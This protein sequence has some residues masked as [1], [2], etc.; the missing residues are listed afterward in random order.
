MKIAIALQNSSLAGKKFEI[1]ES[2]SLTVGRSVGSNIQ[3]NPNDEKIVSGNHA[4]IRFET[5]GFYLIDHNSTNGTFVNGQRI[6]RAKLNQG[7]VIHF[8]KNGPQATVFIDD[9]HQSFAPQTILPQIQQPA[10]HQQ[11]SQKIPNFQPQPSFNANIQEQPNLNNSISFVGLGSGVVKTEKES[12]TG[13]YVGIAVAIFAIIFLSLIVALIMF[14]S[15]GPVAAVI[16]S[17]VAF[18]PA[19]FYILPLI[20]LD[21]YD[22]EPPWLLSM[23]FAWGALVA[24]IASFIV[25]TIIG[26]IAGREIG[27]IVSAPIIEEATKGIGVLLVLIFFRREFDDIL[28]GIVYAGVVALG[29]ATVENILYYGRVINEGGMQCGLFEFARGNQI[30]LSGIFLMRGIL[31]PFAHVTFTAMI[32]IGCGIARE[33]HKLV[34]RIIF[35]ILGYFFAVFLHALWNGSATFLGEGFLIFYI[36]VQVPFFIIFAIFAFW[37]MWRQNRILREMLTLE[38]SRGLIT[39]SQF[40][41]A[42]SAFKSSFWLLGGIFAGKFNARRKF[43]RAVGKLGLSYWHIQRATAAQGQTGSFQ[44]NPILREEVL[45]LRDKV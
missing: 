23:A 37:I 38:N 21:R 25:N 8:G 6:N 16:A 45:Q 31:S 32:G 9:I 30:C 12:Q 27:A 35:P 34:F 19:C 40:A 7:D 3:F 42:T 14:A 4:Y 17:V 11:V 39:D 2:G 1:N 18:V 44:T 33:S 13:R 29:F 36:L 5:D 22:P 15:I 41:T 28:D 10:F 24:V 43:L 20:W 26:G